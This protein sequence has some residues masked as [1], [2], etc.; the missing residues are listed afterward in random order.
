[1][2]RVLRDCIKDFPFHKKTM[3]G[4]PLIY[5]DSAATT[6]KPREVLDAMYS[7]YT[8]DYAP[9]HRS[10]YDMASHASTSYESVR[11]KVARFIGATNPSEI[12]YTKGTTE[13]LNLIA[14][15]YGK[16]LNRGDE[17]IITEMEHHANIVPWKRLAE[18]KGLRLIVAPVLD[19]G[20]L[21]MGALH[22][23]ITE[24]TKLV[25]VAHVSNV[26]GTINNIAK[27]S[28]MAHAVGAKVV[29][30]GAQAV[31]HL[32]VNVEMLGCDFY[33]FSGHKMYGP[34][35]IGILW[36]RYELLEEMPP[37]LGGG[38]MV[39]QVSFE[40]ISYQLPPLR[41][42]AGTPAIAEVIGL[43]AAID[44]LRSFDRMEI[45]EKE[46]KLITTMLTKLKN[47]A[48]VRILGSGNPR[49][50]VISFTIDGH[51]PLDIATILGLKG[52]AARSGHMCAQ[53]LIRRFNL[54]GVVRISTAIYTSYGDIATFLETL[55]EA[56]M[57]LKPELS[58]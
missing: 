21:D 28:E 3:N 24:N 37:F 39:D 51:H 4:K 30:D 26:L 11:K 23:L 36:G 14:S 34:T 27:I 46:E 22:E 41:F 6:Q 9:V 43:G 48:G 8:E 1:M 52:I 15:S 10:V 56:T 17:I 5:L 55:S 25:C 13:G 35:G 31:A 33:T 54:E 50:S 44:Y 20:V 58:Y 40:T 49:T 18:E 19:S 45:L 12:V 32:P 16:L 57:L 53:P 42:E 7:F 29:V 38:D 2:A 47:M